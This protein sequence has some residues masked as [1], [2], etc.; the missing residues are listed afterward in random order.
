MH[1]RRF[2]TSIFSERVSFNSTPVSVVDTASQSNPRNNNKDK[3][4]AQVEIFWVIRPCSVVVGYQR[5]RGPCCL[6]LQ[7]EGVGDGKNGHK[8]WSGVQVGGTS[9][10]P[11][12]SDLVFTLKMEA[13][14]TSETSVSYHNTTRRHN[15]EYLD[16]N[17][18]SRENPHMS[19]KWFSLCN[20]NQNLRFM[21]L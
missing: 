17:L 7:G 10:Y 4:W 13:A 8:Y 1:S 18:L 15:P 16:L 3:K 2:D 9:R 6:H 11:L 21:S 5:F 19:Q 20:I 12:G 14:W